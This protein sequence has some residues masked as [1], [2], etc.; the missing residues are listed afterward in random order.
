MIVI[1]SVYV[2]AIAWLLRLQIDKVELEDGPGVCRGA[3]FA[4]N[5]VTNTLLGSSI[6]IC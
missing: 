6:T 3:N 2:L 4:P 1:G 5:F